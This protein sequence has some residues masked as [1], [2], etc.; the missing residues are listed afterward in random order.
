MKDLIAIL[1]DY[2]AGKITKRD[3]ETELRLREWSATE[4]E[5]VRIEK[6]L[7]AERDGN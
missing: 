1:D 7:N 4:A 2:K 6:W 5:R 3:A